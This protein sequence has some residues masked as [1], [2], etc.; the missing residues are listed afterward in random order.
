MRRTGSLNLP[1]MTSQTNYEA[2]C[3]AYDENGTSRDEAPRK[4]SN[5]WTLKIVL[6]ARFVS[7]CRTKTYK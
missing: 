6:L 2:R 5:Y 3:V 1:D 4:S 7:R